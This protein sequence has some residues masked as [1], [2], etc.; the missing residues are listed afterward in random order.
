MTADSSFS[1]FPKRNLF[2]RVSTCQPISGMRKDDWLGRVLK[3]QRKWSLRTTPAVFFFLSKIRLLGAVEMC[4]LHLTA[5]ELVALLAQM[6]PRC[7]FFNILYAR[8]NP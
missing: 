3:I 2:V 7:T 1:S 4:G 5:A 8:W 6:L